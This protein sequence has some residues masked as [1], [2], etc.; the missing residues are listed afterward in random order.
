MPQ[1]TDRYEF[2]A[3]A[4]DLDIIGTRLQAWAAP[5]QIRESDEICFIA[6][7]NIG[8]NNE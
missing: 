8:H 3:C 7:G 4:R 2:H 1:R 5:A 6:P